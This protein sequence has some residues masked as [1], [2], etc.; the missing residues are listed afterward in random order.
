[1]LL[2]KSTH[3]DINRG[4]MCYPCVMFYRH[5]VQEVLTIIENLNPNKDPQRIA[6]DCNDANIVTALPSPECVDPDI[7]HSDGRWG[8]GA[9]REG[10][11]NRGARKT[12]KIVQR[13][14]THEWQEGKGHKETKQM[15]MIELGVE[16]AVHQILL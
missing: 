12:G 13:K 5:T 14:M 4:H 10:A 1:M 6:L 8:H 9:R 2:I 16:I 15:R 3:N 7:D 11:E